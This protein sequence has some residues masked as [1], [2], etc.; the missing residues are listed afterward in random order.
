MS[1]TSVPT[2]QNDLPNNGADESS[3][4]KHTVVN[5]EGAD[6]PWDPKNF[7]KWKKWVILCTVTDGA[8]IVTCVS[9]LYVSIP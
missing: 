4:E 2:L 5:F 7:P 6:D 3:S 1:T 8:A 9:S